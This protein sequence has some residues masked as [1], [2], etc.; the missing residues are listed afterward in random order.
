MPFIAELGVDE[1][2]LSTHSWGGGFGSSAK[3]AIDTSRGKRTIAAFIGRAFSTDICNRF[4][5]AFTV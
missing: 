3:T 4:E 2:T 1:Q 5:T